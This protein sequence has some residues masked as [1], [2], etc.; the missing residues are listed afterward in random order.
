MPL[1]PVV[2][3]RDCV[4]RQSLPDE[5]RGDSIATRG[6]QLASRLLAP[7]W[8][9]ARRLAS[10]ERATVAAYAEATELVEPDAHRERL[11]AF[12]SDHHARLCELEQWCE[13]MASPCEEV[14][15][16]ETVF[17][18]DAPV[19]P[20]TVLLAMWQSENE[21]ARDYKEALAHFVPVPELRDS[22]ARGLE[23]AHK[24]WAW[25]ALQITRA[26]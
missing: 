22:F 8:H 5:S 6:V 26:D 7:I 23:D 24:H 19:E 14:V 9:R 2:A 20:V 18:L 3:R 16:P 1:G 13:V 15:G 12:R 17:A 11:H 25:L 10:L 21:L 4:Q